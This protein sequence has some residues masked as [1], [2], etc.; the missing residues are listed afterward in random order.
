MP[1]RYIKNII[2]TVTVYSSEN[3]LSSTYNLSNVFSDPFCIMSF[4]LNLPSG[5]QF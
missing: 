4:I 1:L 5:M 3:R 2:Y